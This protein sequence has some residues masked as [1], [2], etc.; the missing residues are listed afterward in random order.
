[1]RKYAMLNASPRKAPVC[2]ISAE[3]PLAKTVDCERG[4][5]HPAS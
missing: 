1:M 3:D 4:G 2:N 5:S